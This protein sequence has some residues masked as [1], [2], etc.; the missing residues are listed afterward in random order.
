MERTHFLPFV[1]RRLRRFV[2]RAEGQKTLIGNLVT[3]IGLVRDGGARLENPRLGYEASVF[4]D[5]R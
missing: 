2:A 4:D 3:S 1:P 5:P